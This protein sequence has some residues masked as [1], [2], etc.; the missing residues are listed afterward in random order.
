MTKDDSLDVV[1]CSVRLQTVLPRVSGDAV[2]HGIRPQMF[3]TCQQ[4]LPD[5][6]NPAF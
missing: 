2:R 3:R 4:P 1:M 5:E 6:T